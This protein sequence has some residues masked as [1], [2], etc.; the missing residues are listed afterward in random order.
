MRPNAA[1]RDH[2]LPRYTQLHYRVHSL[3]ILL[4]ARHLD[5]NAP[6]ARVDPF[7]AENVKSRA[8]VNKPRQKPLYCRRDVENHFGE[9]PTFQPTGTASVNTAALGGS[10]PREVA[11]GPQ[12]P[13]CRHPA[14]WSTSAAQRRTNRAS[15]REGDFATTISLPGREQLAQ[16]REILSRLAGG[17]NRRECLF[18]SSILR[19]SDFGHA[20]SERI[21]MR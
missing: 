1:S 9:L 7:D 2:L 21:G 4:Y 3:R 14:A 10:N 6:S 12:L 18:A 16:A 11:T 5:K 19:T 15:V 8:V 20:G 13:D 17:P